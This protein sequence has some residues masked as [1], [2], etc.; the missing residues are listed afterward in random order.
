MGEAKKALVVGADADLVAA[1]AEATTADCALFYSFAVAHRLEEALGYRGEVIDI[2]A[3]LRALD[4]TAGEWA[5]DFVEHLRKSASWLTDDLL[6]TAR[7]RLHVDIFWPMALASARARAVTDRLGGDWEI[8]ALGVTDLERDALDTGA[9]TPELIRGTSPGLGQR[10]RESSAA[11]RESRRLSQEAAS[12]R[13]ELSLHAD[14]P[15]V[16]ALAAVPIHLKLLESPTREL[17]ARGW[18]CVVLQVY[19]LNDLS[20]EAT[21]VGAS[22]VNL[23]RFIPDREAPKTSPTGG[24]RSGELQLAANEWART[25][26]L[27]EHQARIAAGLIAE[28]VSSQRFV[29][30]YET[31]LG[32][33]R[34]HVVLSLSE[35]YPGI[36]P[37][38][39]ASRRLGIPTVHVQH[40]NIPRIARMSDFRYDAFCVFGEAYAETLETLGTP[41]ERLRVTGS[42]FMDLEPP[43]HAIAASRET[44]LVPSAETPFTI[45][46]IGGYLTDFSSQAL[47]YETLAM[48][49]E[50][51]EGRPD[52]RV[53]VKLHPAVNSGEWVM[54]YE[55]AITEHPD[56]SVEI[57]RE[58]GTY[59]LIRSCDCVVTRGSTVAF[60][61]AWLRKPVILV[62][63]LGSQT[64]LPLDVE[65]TA[66]VASDPE[67][68]AECATQLRSGFVVPEEAF[69]AVEQ[70]YFSGADGRAGERIADICEELAGTKAQ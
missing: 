42:P 69:E 14:R 49:L 35:L 6:T 47:L 33:I 25:R 45:L 26:E 40:G 55:A 2:S 34:P 5:S 43:E 4:S 54:G 58:G 19:A 30:G 28:L 60:E 50:Y 16:V 68:F 29:R 13:H 3:Q 10:I 64:H 65:G 9:R 62:N 21:A 31:V 70:R 37:V 8:R 52:V 20:P 39:A 7:R 67:E 18:D 46:F 53:I 48:V 57:L 56:A 63:A 51:A 15:T 11:R 41:R 32:A 61:A 17:Q 44:P 66:L 12:L 1:A 24:C 59:E 22:C 36:E 23:A 38:A 27:D